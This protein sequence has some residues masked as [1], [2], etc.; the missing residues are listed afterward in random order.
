MR[1]NLNKMLFLITAMEIEFRVDVG[2]VHVIYIYV[3]NTSKLVFT[4]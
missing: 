2:Y 4:C 1:N 3:Y